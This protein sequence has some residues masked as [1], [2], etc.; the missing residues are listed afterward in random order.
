MQPCIVKS[1]KG[2]LVVKLDA[3]NFMPALSVKAAMYDG[4]YIAEVLIGWKS[5]LQTA[6]NEIDAAFDKVEELQDVCDR[7]YRNKLFVENARG[8][9][10]EELRIK[11]RSW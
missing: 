6:M 2:N 10:A 7:E 11:H 4:K 8:N 5:R 1:N 3:E 9:L